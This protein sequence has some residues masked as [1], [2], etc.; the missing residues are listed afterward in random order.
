MMN[1]PQSQSR[2]RL[3]SPLSMESNDSNFLGQYQNFGGDA[4]SAAS[5]RTT[6]T[7]QNSPPLSNS[8]DNSLSSRPSNRSPGASNGHI[9]SSSSLA[10]SS[11]GAGFYSP[12]KT[13]FGRPPQQKSRHEDALREHYNMLKSYLAPY[14]RAESGANRPT[15]ARDK[16][17]RLSPTQFHELSTDV[18]DEL[19][20]REDDRRRPGGIVP[21][22]LPPKS[23]FHPKRNQARQK[24]S[25]LPA[26]RFRQLATDVYFELERRIP[27]FVNSHSPSGSVASSFRSQ[28]RP[29]PPNGMPRQNSQPNGFRGGP[30]GPGMGMRPNGLGP[31]PGPGPG[32]GPGQGL[33]P[34][35]QS[36]S[37]QDEHPPRLD[38]RSRS[39][40]SAGSYG[41]PLPKT[42]QSNTM[43]PNKSTM[44]EDD[45]TDE[46]DE[47]FG[48]DK[49]VSGISS[50][51]SASRSMGSDQDREIIR[52][53]ETQVVDLQG[54]IAELEEKLS[55]TELEVE[56]NKNRHQD[57]EREKDEWSSARADLGTR[58]AES[59][60]A[61][62]NLHAELEKAHQDRSQHETDLRAETERT[63]SDMQLELDDMK[64]ENEALRAE[65]VEAQPAVN[66]EELNDLREQLTKQRQLTDEVR[67]NAAQFLQE[68]R[69]LSEQSELAMEN[70]EQLR[71]Q[72]TSLEVENEEWKSRYTKAKTQLRTLRA[73]SM[74]LSVQPTSTAFSARQELLSD[75]GLVQDMDVTAYQ[76]AIDELLHAARESSPD[77]LMQKAKNV[78]GVVR[79]ITAGA[80]GDFSTLASPQSST[81]PQAPHNS[82]STSTSALK[83]QV[84]RNANYLVSAART[85][86]TSNGLAPLSL[87]DAA[88]NNLT[89]SVVEFLKA[90]GIKPS[91]NAELNHDGNEEDDEE[92]FTEIAPL[93]TNKSAASAAPV[94]KAPVPPQKGWFSM[95]KSN[96]DSS[97]ASDD[98]DDEYDY[99]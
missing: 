73:T 91:T 74:G 42:F 9:S 62:D 67:N 20:R 82:N 96:R 50:K 37:P 10:R 87:L 11:D 72:I 99:S 95:L 28:G 15:K 65:T 58:L 5:N 25:T 46:E 35:Y 70:E 12:S 68:M 80:D 86:A 23:S 24:L 16:L 26:E 3:V 61:M 6:A 33:G 76:I 54:K 94:L 19:L 69:L 49:V 81:S 32:L 41:R 89:A 36:P 27:R 53:Y 92:E 34:G 40:S 88:A 22:F 43:V 8:T 64:R 45:E 31:G 18:Y 66:T 57:H 14:L 59:Q 7:S 2:T 51:H 30:G 48:L 75:K 71:S 38:S 4:Y 78:V 93:S 85:H 39:G 77:T 55:A 98:D 21:P 63:I 52:D 97:I 56:T 90:A 44:V 1:L 17:L 60:S 13:E 29:G 83:S 84:S 79:N 47:E